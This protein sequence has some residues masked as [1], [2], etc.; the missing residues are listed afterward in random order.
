MKKCYNAVFILM[1]KYYSFHRN[2]DTSSACGQCCPMPNEGCAPEERTGPQKPASFISNTSA[3]VDSWDCI[4]TSLLKSCMMWRRS[5]K[6]QFSK[7][8]HKL[9]IPHFLG[10]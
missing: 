7:H 8:G 6:A 1:N 9:C 3:A 10:I 2:S 4:C 5:P